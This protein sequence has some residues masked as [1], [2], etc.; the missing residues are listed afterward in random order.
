MFIKLIMRLLF[1]LFAPIFPSYFHTQTCPLIRV[2]AVQY[3]AKGVEFDRSNPIIALRV[4]SLDL[5]IYSH[6]GFDKL[7][8]LFW[9]K[10]LPK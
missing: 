10:L 5:I 8:A 1:G 3:I 6:S 7:A 4:I 9:V 2:C